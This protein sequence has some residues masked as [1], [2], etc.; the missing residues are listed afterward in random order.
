M[1]K[2]RSWR[3][4]LWLGLVCLT[5]PQFSSSQ[6]PQGAA[7]KP[8]DIYFIDVEGGAATL[9]VTPEKQSLLMDCGWKRPDQRDVKR[10]LY[11]AKIRK[12]L[13]YCGVNKSAPFGYEILCHVAQL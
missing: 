9:I 13:R 6:A 7:A 11:V 2:A 5:R 3:V 4:L 12:S 10:I 8:L 1:K